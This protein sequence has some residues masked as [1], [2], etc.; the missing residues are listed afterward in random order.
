MGGQWCTGQSTPETWPK[1]IISNQF[2]GS[3]SC[4]PP[5]PRE[6]SPRVLTYLLTTVHLF[7]SSVFVFIYLH[8]RFKGRQGLIGVPPQPLLR[9]LNAEQEE[10]IDSPGNKLWR[11]LYLC[12]SDELSGGIM[13]VRLHGQIHHP[14]H[15]G[16]YKGQ[17]GTKA[18]NNYT[19]TWE[20]QIIGI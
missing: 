7:L 3:H 14:P 12:P 5:L 8:Y 19:M 15:H 16:G 20:K 13:A 11:Y 17:K 2:N 1:Y 10:M 18:S 4:P 6:H 9:H